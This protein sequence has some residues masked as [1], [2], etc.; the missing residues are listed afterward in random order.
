MKYKYN[1]NYKPK[2]TNYKLGIIIIVI[3]IITFI[4]SLFLFREN[5]VI[6]RINNVLLK[7]IESISNLNLAQK[8]KESSATKKSL[9]KENEKLKAENNEI[10]LKLIEY[11][12]LLEENESL[13]KLLEIKTTFQHYNLA[14]ARILIR[15]H[16]NYNQ[17][18][19]VNVGTKDGVKNEQAVIHKDGLVGYVSSVT[20][21]TDCSSAVFCI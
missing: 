1:Y 6:S 4:I 12:K 15:A 7:P 20:E 14:A 19:I 18:F 2:K 16:D 13:R 17:T 11:Q 9:I 21:N 3:I 10:S 8:L 5:K